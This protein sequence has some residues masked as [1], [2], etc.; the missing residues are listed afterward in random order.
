AV[1]LQSQDAG[2]RRRRPPAQ[3]QRLRCRA[4]LCRAACGRRRPAC[5]RLIRQLLGRASMNAPLRSLRQEKMRI[6]GKLVGADRV[7]EVFNPY[8][9]QV[10][11]TVPKAGLGQIR[12]AYEIAATYKPKLS[13]H[14]RSKILRRTGE[15][16]DSRRQEIAE[17]IT[18]E[19]GL[20]LK[21]T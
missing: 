6:G 18:A 17:L 2:A 12:E 9:E 16:L 8:T 11:G 1:L 21:D 20:S 15:L 13:R 3:L 4:E 7:I 5:G 19:S 10:I 14:D